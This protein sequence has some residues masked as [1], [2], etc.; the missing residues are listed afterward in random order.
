MRPYGDI[1]AGKNLKPLTVTFESLQQSA[2]NEGYP[3]PGIDVRLPP[4]K[5]Y[6]DKPWTR[7]L[8]EKEPSSISVRNHWGNL[9]SPEQKRE[10][11]NKWITEQ[12]LSLKA[13]QVELLQIKEI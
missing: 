6:M 8:N 11:V 9:E 4:I 1:I 12:G 3:L 10:F 5:D 13:P 2:L 7:I